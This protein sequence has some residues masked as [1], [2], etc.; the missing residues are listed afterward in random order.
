MD[1]EIH[2]LDKLIFNC[3]SEAIEVFDIEEDHHHLVAKL[4]DEQMELCTRPRSLYSKENEGQHVFDEF[5]SWLQNDSAEIEDQIAQSLGI[6]SGYLS[7]LGLSCQCFLG[8]KISG[9]VYND[10]IKDCLMLLVPDESILAVSKNADSK[11]NWISTIATVLSKPK[12][13]VLMM[14]GDNHNEKIFGLSLKGLLPFQ[15]PKIKEEILQVK[16]IENSFHLTSDIM[17][18]SSHFIKDILPEGQIDKTERSEMLQRSLNYFKENETFQEEDYIQ[19]VFDDESRVEDFRN[20]RANMGVAG[21]PETS[22]EI[23]RDAV[24]DQSRMFKSILKL[25]RNFHIYIH[26]DRKLIERG[27]DDNGR[28]YYKIFYEKEQ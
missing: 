27:I 7:E 8:F 9:V 21:E 1:Q 4:L 5:F 14:T 25:D 23:S 6:L 13:A 22:F 17:K 26:G 12:I 2:L 3:Q 16:P 18:H 28:K 20:F 10:E 24:K 19:K 11:T 15:I